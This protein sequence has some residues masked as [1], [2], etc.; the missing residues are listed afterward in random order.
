[1]VDQSNLYD[2]EDTKLSRLFGL[3]EKEDSKASRS[4]GWV[5]TYRKEMDSLL[6]LWVL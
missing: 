2:K 6:V 5:P 1:M 3:F 4:H